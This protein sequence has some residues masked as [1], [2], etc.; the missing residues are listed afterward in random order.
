MMSLQN[1]ALQHKGK[2]DES[3]WREA[4]WAYSQCNTSEV[5]E[6]TQLFTK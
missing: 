4:A 1:P 5:P 3:A 2:E 6:I